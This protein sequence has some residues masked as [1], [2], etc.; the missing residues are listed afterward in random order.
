MA[1]VKKVIKGKDKPKA[2]HFI[3][4][5]AQP[6]KDKVFEAEELKDF[7]TK[8]FKV[9]GKTANLGELVTISCE[10]TKNIHIKGSIPFSK[11]YLKYLSK[12]FLKKHEVRDYLH[13]VATTKDSYEFKYFKLENKE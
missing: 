13:V 1:E 12:K 2:V 10:D 11:R 5:C 7:L 6:V 4:N 3:L 9:N 8:K